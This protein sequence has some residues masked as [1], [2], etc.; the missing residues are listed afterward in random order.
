MQKVVCFT[1]YAQLC[2]LSKA[3]QGQFKALLLPTDW[4]IDSRLELQLA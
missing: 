1:Q 4:I 2:Y 3:V